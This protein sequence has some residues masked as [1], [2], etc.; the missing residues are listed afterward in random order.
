MQMN[1]DIINLYKPSG[2]TSHDMVDLVRR[3][4]G[5][6]T[7]GHAGT[8]DP[9]A[10]GVL[11]ILVGRQATRRQQEFMSLKK[12]YHAVLHLGAASDTDDLTGKIV[13]SECEFNITEKEIVEILKKFEGEIQQ[14]PPAYS[15]IKLQGRKAYEL[16]R[17]GIKADLKPRTVKIERITLLNYS[18]PKLEIEVDCGSGTY[19]RALARDIGEALGC[20]AYV[21][22]LIRTR[23]GEF[24]SENGILPEKLTF[25]G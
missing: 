5:E 1:N 20:G 8:L 21:E 4:T 17:K 10:E 24:T 13:V 15:A 2:P 19:I 16:A 12:Q 18:W 25:T 14:M 9:F 3:A 6:R 7:V 11:I 22:K 23:V